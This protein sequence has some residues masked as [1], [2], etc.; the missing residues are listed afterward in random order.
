M[1]DLNF[2]ISHQDLVT[3]FEFSDIHHIGNVRIDTKIKPAACIQPE[4]R[5]YVIQRM[6]VTLCFKVNRPGHV[7]FSNIFDIL[8]LENFRI[9]TKIGFVNR[10]QKGQGFDLDEFQGLKKFFYYHRWIP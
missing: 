2:K 6:C 7:N 8:D 5:K 1:F 10:S 3:N 9:G 4:L